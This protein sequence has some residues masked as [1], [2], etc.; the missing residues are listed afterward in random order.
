MKY[1]VT[2]ENFNTVDT[3]ELNDWYNCPN[4]GYDSLDVGFN[5]CPNCGESII[6]ELEEA[7]T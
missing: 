2:T 4:C 1:T 7:T 5:Y 6:F 3:W